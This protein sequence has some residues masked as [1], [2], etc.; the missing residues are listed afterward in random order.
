MCMEKYKKKI[1]EEDVISSLKEE[2]KNTFLV[3]GTKYT[4]DEV[5]DISKK[6]TGGD[7]RNLILITRDHT[8]FVHFKE[9]RARRQHN[10]NEIEKNITKNGYIL[11]NPIFVKYSNGK[12]II[13][14]GAHRFEILKKKIEA[15]EKDVHGNDY[16]IPY[17]VVDTDD[18]LKTAQILNHAKSNWNNIDYISSYF[19]INPNYANLNEYLLKNSNYSDVPLWTSIAIL[20]K[21]YDNSANGN[22]KK[23]AKDGLL[24]FPIDQLPDICRKANKAQEVASICK[25]LGFSTKLDLFVN[26]VI[27]LSE[28]GNGFNYQQFIENLKVY[29][30]VLLANDRNN[31]KKNMGIALKIHN[32]GGNSRLRLA[33]FYKAFDE[34]NKDVQAECKRILEENKSKN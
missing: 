3:P 27:W 14:D 22:S 28:Y 7:I 31:F 21:C 13:L 16:F 33:T 18:V 34:S 30:K 12:L 32:K 11:D 6:S 9:N 10:L 26:S 2:A 17:V 4:I 8:M 19:T 24:K 20:T 15:N 5:I 25:Q 23:L 1:I 29:G